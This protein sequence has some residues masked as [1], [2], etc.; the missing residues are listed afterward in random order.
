[1]QPKGKQKVNKG[2]DTGKQK[3]NMVSACFDLLRPQLGGIC[4]GVQIF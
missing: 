4:N 2:G 1:M 3:V